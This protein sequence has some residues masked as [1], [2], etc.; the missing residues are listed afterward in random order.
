MFAGSAAP[1][2][3]RQQAVEAMFPYVERQL[4]QGVFLHN[5]TRHM[6]GLYHAQPGGRMWRQV[7]STDAV[8]PGAGLEVL[9]RG[10]SVVGEQARRM[11]AE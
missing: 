5:I 9:Q 6:L 10:L 8:K 1:V 3:T 11:A 2:A 7:L 4:A